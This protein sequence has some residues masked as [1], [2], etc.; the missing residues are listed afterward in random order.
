MKTKCDLCG[1]KFKYDGSWRSPKHCFKCDLALFQLEE[2]VD[3]YLQGNP[4]GWLRKAMIHFGWIF[5]SYPLTAAYLNLAT[6]IIFDFVIGNEGHLTNQD[7]EEIHYMAATVDE[8]KVVLESAALII[9]DGNKIRP[10]R[11]T[12]EIDRIRIA[13]YRL[14]TTE[15]QEKVQEVRG[16]LSVALTLA[17][18]KSGDYRPQRPLALFRILGQNIINSGLE[19]TRS[20]NR[21]MSE[22]SFEDACLAINDKQKR[23]ILWHMS[24]FSTGHTRVIE[25]IEKNGSSIDLVFDSEMM[26]FMDRI[27]QRYRKRL[28]ARTRSP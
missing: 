24:G 11:L 28:R 8:V 10:G 5:E 9:V 13:Q 25:E 17:I 7:L 20:I 22:I 19:D 1:T 15:F 26:V 18:V 21:K 16:V 12:E 23:R 4:P 3:I 14:N 2:S 6:E 27:R